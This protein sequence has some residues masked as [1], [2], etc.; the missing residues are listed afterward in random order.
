[1]VLR[2][3]DKVRTHLRRGLES[4]G[5]A[6]NGVAQ[7]CFHSGTAFCYGPIRYTEG[8]YVD[9]PGGVSAT[10]AVWLWIHAVA[11][12]HCICLYVYSQFVFLVAESLFD[13]EPKMVS[14][15]CI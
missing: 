13:M 4:S 14:L 1:M 15:T 12:S 5:V 11:L 6:T 9:S 2:G 3:S 10:G 7:C 8:A